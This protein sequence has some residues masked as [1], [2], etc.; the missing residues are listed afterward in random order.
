L[1]TCKSTLTP[2]PLLLSN[3]SEPSNRSK[4]ETI[5]EILE[6]P[7]C[8]YEDFIHEIDELIP[9]IPDSL[10]KHRLPSEY[11]DFENFDIIGS[12][13]FFSLSESPS[14][15]LIHFIE[16][17]DELI[18]PTLIFTIQDFFPLDV[19]ALLRTLPPKV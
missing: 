1:F 17:L 3:P 18:P 6:F 15:A 13:N 9:S 11:V 19:P 4:L 2:C 7:F 10:L 8:P 5:E 16:V 12:N 14:I